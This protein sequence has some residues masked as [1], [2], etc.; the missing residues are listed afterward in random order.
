[1]KLI[2]VMLTIIELEI[3]RLFFFHIF[4]RRSVYVYTCNYMVVT[5]LEQFL[6]F[7]QILLPLKMYIFVFYAYVY[8]CSEKEIRSW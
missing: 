5:F 4:Q 3:L 6:I 7:I 2:I 1:M 8:F